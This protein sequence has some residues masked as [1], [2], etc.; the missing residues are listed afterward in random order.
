MAAKDRKPCFPTTPGTGFLSVFRDYSATFG[1][2]AVVA[3]LLAFMC[4]PWL[5]QLLR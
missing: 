4:L 5:L 1:V 3:A 2:L